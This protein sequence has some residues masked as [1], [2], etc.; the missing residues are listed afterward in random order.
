L[1]RPKY[2][3]H[4]DIIKNVFPKKGDILGARIIPYYCGD[5]GFIEFYKEIKAGEQPQEQGFLKNCIQCGKQ[6][7]IASEQ[8]QYCGAEQ[9]KR[10]K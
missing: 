10:K 8:C 2:S 1:C 9:M 3:A 6:I 4:S 5:C 7:P